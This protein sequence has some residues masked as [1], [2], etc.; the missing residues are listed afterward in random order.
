MLDFD[1]GN[2]SEM[3]EEGR[4]GKDSPIRAQ[5]FIPSLE[6]LIKGSE[7]SFRI[8]H[9]NNPNITGFPAM[10]KKYYLCLFPACLLTSTDTLI[11][12]L[13]FLQFISFHFRN[14]AL[15]IHLLVYS[16]PAF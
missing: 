14:I 6:N 16:I 13:I 4:G 8:I 11:L 10:L 9:G 5:A 2:D 3:P 12:C 15:L 1:N 7:T